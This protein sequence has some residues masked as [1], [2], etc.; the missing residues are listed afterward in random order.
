[1]KSND[2]EPAAKYVTKHQWAFVDRGE[3][4]Q[5]ALSF[6]TLVLV[7]QLKFLNTAVLIQGV[8]EELKR[9]RRTELRGQETEGVPACLDGQVEKFSI[10]ETYVRS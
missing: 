3:V 6:D 10:H 4:K 7:Y 2:L 8:E 5:P 9:E 1:M